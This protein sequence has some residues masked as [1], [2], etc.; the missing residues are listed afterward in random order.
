MFVGVHLMLAEAT[1]Q[2]HWAITDEEGETWMTAAGQVLRHYSV[3]ATQ[4]TLDWIAFAGITGGMY[5]PR[6]VA[7]ALQKREEARSRPGK[8]VRPAAFNRPPGPPPGAAMGPLGDDGGPLV[9]LPDLEDLP[10]AGE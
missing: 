4:K 8:V 2:P 6:I 5:G 10:P 1:H 7:T 9:I 3:E